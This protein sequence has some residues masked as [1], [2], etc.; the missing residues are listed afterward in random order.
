MSQRELE[1]MIGER[2]I[3]GQN[4]AMGIG[5]DHRAGDRAL[6]PVVAVADA[7]LHGGKRLRT[8]SEPGVAAMVLETGQPLIITVSAIPAA[9]DLTDRSHWTTGGGDVE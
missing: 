7:D 9:D 1:E 2:G 8:R 6:R 4:R 3:P 5:T